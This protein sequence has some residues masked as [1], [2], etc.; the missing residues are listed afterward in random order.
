MDVGQWMMPAYK[1]YILKDSNRTCSINFKLQRKTRIQIFV[2]DLL[3]VSETAT[4]E[5]HGNQSP[6]E[7]NVREGAERPHP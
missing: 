6:S 1:S 7:F 2:Q 5:H 4:V 3:R